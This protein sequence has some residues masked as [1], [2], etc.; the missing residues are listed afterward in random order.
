VLQ[1]ILQTVQKTLKQLKTDCAV[2]EATIQQRL[3]QDAINRDINHSR[4]VNGAALIVVTLVIL[5]L[6]A[7]AV[8]ARGAGAVCSQGAG[9]SISNSVCSTG[10]LQSLSAWDQTL[11]GVFTALVGG[12]L[13]LLLVFGGGAGFAWRGVPVLNKAHHKRLEE[14][15]AA[16]HRAKQ[17][18][19]VQWEE[20]FASL[21]ETGDR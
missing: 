4:T 14:Y 8:A 21:A 9:H 12:L 18:A 1:A 19:E 11:E 17:E 13:I 3:T 2:I 6:L 15:M 7:L 20:Y 16:V 10:L 5:L